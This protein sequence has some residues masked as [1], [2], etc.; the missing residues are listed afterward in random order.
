M[1]TAL[2]FD[3]CYEFPFVFAPHICSLAQM[4][5][6]VTRPTSLDTC[7]DGRSISVSFLDDAD[8]DCTLMFPFHRVARGPLEVETLGYRE[9]RL[10]V[11]RRTE[12]ISRFTGL[13]SLDVEK[14]TEPVTWEM[15]RDI[16]RQIDPF[17]TDYAHVYPEMVAIA[18]NEGR[19]IGNADPAVNW[20]AFTLRVPAAS[21]FARSGVLWGAEHG[22]A[23][24]GTTK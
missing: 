15:A 2:E 24:S 7:R 14:M 10:D 19:L 18:E 4:S 21:Y 3:G 8:V 1:G 23:Y 16:L 20:T 11:F 13:S 22:L 12:W 9:P 17:I 5:Y 6:I